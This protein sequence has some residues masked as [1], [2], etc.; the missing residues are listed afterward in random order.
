M[1]EW[2]D[3]FAELC[4]AKKVFALATVVRG[5]N[6]GA[7]LI[8]HPDGTYSGLLGDGALTES[9]IGDAVRLMALE[10][11][12]TIAYD[13]VHVFIETYA[14]PPRLLIVGGVHTAI[15]LAQYAQLLGFRVTIVDGRGRF[16]TRERFPDVDELI[17]EWPDDVI[18]RLQID[19]S[20]Y[21]VVLTHDPKFDLPTLKALATTQPRYIGAMGSRETRRQHMA[22][23]R[24]Q[25]VSDEFL[26][27]VYGPVGLDLG[28]RSPA[29]MALAIMA[30]IIA[31][32]YNRRGG[33]LMH[34]AAE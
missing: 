3:Q 23:L 21:V 13:D 17:V 9:V 15:P 18:P 26:K 14:P 32:R 24:A 10:Q 27:T 5:E 7:K 31:V 6:L 25:G 28:G 33:H 2:F 22:E 19:Q 29:E 20:T 34:A 8:I 16:A 1:S 11:S 4:A 30:Q 12:E